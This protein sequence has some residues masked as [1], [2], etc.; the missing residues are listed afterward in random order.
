MIIQASVH[1]GH[2]RFKSS[3]GR[4][5]ANATTAIIQ[6]SKVLTKVLDFIL[7]TGDDLYITLE[8]HNLEYL[9]HQDLPDSIAT[10]CPSFNGMVDNK[11]EGLLY[12][13]YDDLQQ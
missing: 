8:N 13:L 9:T 2:E 6:S 3:G 1:Q 12:S 7:A 5:V 11:T 10:L 4:C